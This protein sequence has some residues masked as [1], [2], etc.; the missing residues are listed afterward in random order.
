MRPP[1]T[2]L[3]RR[4][5]ADPPEY[6]CACGCGAVAS[7]G[8]PGNIHY[9]WTCVP[10]H[11]RLPSEPGYAPLPAPPADPAAPIPSPG[12]AAASIQPELF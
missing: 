3:G 10:A 9:A 5:R 12:G 11:L 6:R 1:L 2:A 4:P 8:F 7:R